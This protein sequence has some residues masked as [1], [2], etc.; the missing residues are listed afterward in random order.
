METKSEITDA[1]VLSS[2]IEDDTEEII[3][4]ERTYTILTEE[5]PSYDEITFMFSKI[6]A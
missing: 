3:V 6:L 5:A 2:I 4:N 1:N